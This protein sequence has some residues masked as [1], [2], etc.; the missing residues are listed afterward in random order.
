VIRVEAGCFVTYFENQRYVLGKTDAGIRPAIRAALQL[1]RE[2]Q[3][4]EIAS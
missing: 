1:C 4:R 2:N 3:V